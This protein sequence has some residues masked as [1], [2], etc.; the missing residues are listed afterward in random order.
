MI[1]LTARSGLFLKPFADH[2]GRPLRYRTKP[3]LNRNGKT[4]D[5][6][7]TSVN[8]RALVEALI[9]KG[10]GPH[11]ARSPELI[12]ALDSTPPALRHHF[13]RGYFD[14]DGSAFET[15]GVTGRIV[16]ELAGNR[17]LLRAIRT[18]L[19]DDLGVAPSAIVHDKAGHTDAFGTIRWTAPIH[20]C[21]IRGWLYRDCAHCLDSKREILLRS[22]DRRPATKP[23]RF[24]GVS[25]VGAR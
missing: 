19:V 20:I 16:L 23:S 1:E 13:I 12:R 5:M 4:Y 11:K 6:V 22:D 7:F 25:A 10:V 17:Y 14:G 9:D 3:E 15:G 21:K 18:I 24:R 8:S 2:F